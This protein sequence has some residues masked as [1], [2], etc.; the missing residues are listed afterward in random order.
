MFNRFTTWT[1]TALAAVSMAAPAA[2]AEGTAWDQEKVTAIAKEISDAAQALQRSLRRRPPT[3][4][5]QPGKRAF[6]SLREEMQVLS[7]AS[8]RLH[9]ALSEGAGLDETYPT[10][11]RLLRS[12]RR[13]KG[14]LRRINLG[15]P[16][17]SKV[18]AVVEA[19]RKIRPFYDDEP[20]L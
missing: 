3:T 11:R 12:G 10:Y 19:V 16:E 4:L 17:S 8:R 7:T 18:D 5:G 15:E 1:A 14:E 2:L 13:A 6:W 9:Q 20:P